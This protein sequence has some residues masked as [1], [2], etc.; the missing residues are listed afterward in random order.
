MESFV[1]Q[2]RV[3]MTSVAQRTKDVSVRRFQ[4]ECPT[5][6]DTTFDSWSIYYANQQAMTMYRNTMNQGPIELNPD[7]MKLTRDILTV[8]HPIKVATQTMQREGAS[9]LASQYLPLLS[10]L[11]EQLGEAKS[12]WIPEDCRD[13]A[14]DK[15]EVEQLHMIAQQLRDWLH[16]D[17]ASMAHKH[18]TQYDETKGN[19]AVTLLRL[20]SFMDPRFKS[21]RFLREDERPAVRKNLTTFAIQRSEEYNRLYSGTEASAAGA[22]PGQPAGSSNAPAIES[23][24]VVTDET[25]L[26]D[27]EKKSRDRRQKRAVADQKKTSKG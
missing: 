4:N 8:L 2:V 22:Q 10:S 24:P 15:V 21:L 9:S 5:R 27:C 16:R 25:V 12:M 23:Q 26:A 20:S 17:Y 13:G 7:Q 14:E 18:M 11:N 3:Q 6:W 1:K 19:D